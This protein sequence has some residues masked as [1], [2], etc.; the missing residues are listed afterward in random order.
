MTSAATSIAI[1]TSL[2]KA[3]TTT[4]TTISKMSAPMP[5]N[6][7]LLWIN[8]PHFCAGADVIGGIVSG[9]VAPIIRY[10]RGWQIERVRSYCRQKGWQLM[11]SGVDLADH[12]ENFVREKNF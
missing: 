9:D 8:A 2:Q 3:Q 10:M 11:E 1:Q 4:P 5:N 6:T 7:G 12:R